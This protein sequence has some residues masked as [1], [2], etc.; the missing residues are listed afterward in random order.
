MGDKGK[1]GDNNM[2]ITHVKAKS[3]N[4]WVYGVAIRHDGKCKIYQENL[5]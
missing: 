5:Y 4:C 3:A 2:G 1:V